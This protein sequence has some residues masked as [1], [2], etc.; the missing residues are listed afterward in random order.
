MAIFCDMVS[1]FI[2]FDKTYNFDEYSF[3]HTPHRCK[4]HTVGTPKIPLLSE[5]EP[6]SIGI[7]ITIPQFFVDLYY[8]FSK[9]LRTDHNIFEFD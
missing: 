9:I 5:A 1:K 4:L 8:R 2:L 3:L 6:F 7:K